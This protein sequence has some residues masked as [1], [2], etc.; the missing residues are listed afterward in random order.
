MVDHFRILV[1]RF[2]IV[3]VYRRILSHFKLRLIIMNNGLR[4]SVIMEENSLMLV[5][6]REGKEGGS[7]RDQL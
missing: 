1:I 6:E 2:P 7:F 3:I 5:S 4:V